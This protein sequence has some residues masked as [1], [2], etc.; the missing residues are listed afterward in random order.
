[1][2]AD[3]TCYDP[4]VATWRRGIKV[5]ASLEEA[6]EGADCIVIATDHTAFGS[7]DLKA[8]AGLAHKPLAIVDGRHVLAPKAVED[9][10]I[11][12]IGIGRTRDSGLNIRDFRSSL[13]ERKT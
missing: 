3:V 1:M 10:G 12:Y 7:L 9:L 11:T 5:K 4:L 2:G 13:K 8:I 6:V